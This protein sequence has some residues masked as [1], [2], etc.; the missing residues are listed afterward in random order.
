MGQREAIQ[1]I[2]SMLGLPNCD[3]II[4]ASHFFP[5]GP[6]NFFVTE[7]ICHFNLKVIIESAPAAILDSSHWTFVW[8]AWDRRGAITRGYNGGCCGE[9]GG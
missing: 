1:P 6:A 5:Q 4:P 8:S 7:Q 3:P 2:V 9:C